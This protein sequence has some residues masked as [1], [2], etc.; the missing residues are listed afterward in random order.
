MLRRFVQHERH[1]EE[2]RA[3]VD[4]LLFA[5]RDATSG[6]ARFFNIHVANTVPSCFISPSAYA[7]G[8]D[9]IP[10]DSADFTA[11]DRTGFTVRNAVA[12]FN[13]SAADAW[14][15]DAIADT[16]AL[17]GANSDNATDARDANACSIPDANADSTHAHAYAIGVS[18]P[19]SVAANE[20]ADAF[21]KSFRQSDGSNARNGN[22]RRDE[23]EHGP[24]TCDERR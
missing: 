13:S 7:H 15:A 2:D 10:A 9:F 12:N 18:Q 4:L 6:R 17:T 20:H 16:E 19:A 8:T 21:S 5:G 3:I 22:G 23:Y 11:T 1:E 24:A 14:N